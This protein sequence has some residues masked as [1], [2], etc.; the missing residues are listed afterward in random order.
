MKRHP[1]KHV[2]VTAL[3]ALSLVV[4]A[5]GC[6]PS[7]TPRLAPPTQ[8]VEPE[9]ENALTLEQIQQLQTLRS[10]ATAAVTLILPLPARAG[11]ASF[12]FARVD[13][14]VAPGRLD[15]LVFARG[16]SAD[17]PR[18]ARITLTSANDLRLTIF[19]VAAV[20]TARVKPNAAFRYRLLKASRDSAGRICQ[21]PRRENGAIRRLVAASPAVDSTPPRKLRIVI[22]VSP[23]MVNEYR[24]RGDYAE[25][26]GDVADMLND[27]NE[28]M[29]RDVCVTLIQ[30]G[31]VLEPSNSDLTMYGGDVLPNVQAF[32]Q[33]AATANGWP[34]D[35]GH[36]IDEGNGGRAD[37]GGFCTTGRSASAWSGSSDETIANVLLN[38]G[39]EVGHQLGAAHTYNLGDS[40][41]DPLNAYEPG[42]GVSLM[43][44]G[45]VQPYYHGSSMA[46]LDGSLRNHTTAGGCGV[47]SGISISTP[48]VRVPDAAPH[49]PSHTAF[50]LMA[51]PDLPPTGYRWDE[52]ELATQPDMA[53]PFFD[54]SPERSLGRI[55]PL[56]FLD[57]T[58]LVWP[59]VGQWVFRVLGFNSHAQNHQDVTVHVDADT[60][61]TISSVTCTSGS[62]APGGRMRVKWQKGH[63]AAPPYRVTTVRAEIVDE[64]PPHRRYLVAASIP[65]SGSADLTLPLAIPRLRQVRLMLHANGGIFLAVSQEITI[66]E[67]GVP[68]TTPRQQ[69][70]LKGDIR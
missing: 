36:M 59:P 6:S 37:P 9:P 70:A 56:H 41:R 60:P 18:A 47:D 43:S 29:D 26:A 21:V 54:S 40:Q 63:T 44:I 55:Y 20:Y 58:S 17:P 65:N 66:N 5:A 19:D 53:P 7:Q 32:I 62:C 22:A 23:T 13:R 10:D 39:H 31:T 49:V 50:E 15:D 14:P 28:V 64:A 11:V 2:S 57:G 33:N 61:F 51:T 25:L 42:Q 52:F 8:I 16:E 1:R 24:T 45:D 46:L 27:A 68:V 4:M 48:I 3:A 69:E 67:F 12:T 38:F 34:M 30:S 35:L